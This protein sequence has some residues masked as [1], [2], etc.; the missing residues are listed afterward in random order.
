MDGFKNTTKMKYFAA[1]GYAQS[2]ANASSGRMPARGKP[3]SVGLDRAAEKSGRD[4]PM[5]GKP[6]TTGLA[7]AAEKSGRE[8]PARGK[9]LARGGMAGKPEA[10]GLARAAEKSGRTMPAT[11]KPLARGGMAGK[12]ASTGLARA[13]EMSGREMPVRKNEGGMMS[14]RPSAG[15]SVASGNRMSKM[16]AKEERMIDRMMPGKGRVTEREAR[17]LEERFPIDAL[18]KRLRSRMPSAGESVASGN[19]MSRME[20]EEAR[21]MGLKKG[22]LAV[23]PKK[24]K[25]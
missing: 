14:K 8:M 25:R 11:G 17:M 13:A 9:P 10:T 21:A 23:M 3:S 22:G 2:E 12:P 4:M 24:G 19:R 1:G 20:A 16:M 5:R 18:V 6:E 15:E 7:R